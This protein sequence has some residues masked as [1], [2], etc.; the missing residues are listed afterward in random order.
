M[1]NCLRHTD[2]KKYFSVFSNAKLRGN[3]NVLLGEGS[4]KNLEMF[5]LRKR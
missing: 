3:T 5:L 4:G 2:N 1:H